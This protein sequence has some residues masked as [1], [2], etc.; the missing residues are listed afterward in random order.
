M[1][2]IAALQTSRSDSMTS[3]Q[4]ATTRIR[5]VILTK[6]AVTISSHAKSKFLDTQAQATL[7]HQVA[8]N[9]AVL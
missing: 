1:N 7:E 3:Q 6:A 5:S 8:L 2:V 9:R 4:N